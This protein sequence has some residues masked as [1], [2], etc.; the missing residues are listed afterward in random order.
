[1]FNLCFV[2]AVGV[3]T[4]IK[5]N[6]TLRMAYKILQAKF[7]GYSIYNNRDLCVHTNIWS[8]KP[9]EKA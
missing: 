7:S 5:N 6:H 4:D 2:G 3:A 9:T 1:M 8:E